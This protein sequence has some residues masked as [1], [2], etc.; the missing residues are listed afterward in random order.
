MVPDG[1]GT[2]LKPSWEP[3]CLARKPLSEKTVA[4]NCLRWG[5]GAINVDGCRVGTADDLNGGRYS[6]N[7]IGNDGATYG[8]G[9]NKRSASDY[10]QPLGR[11]PAN[12]CLSWPEDEYELRPDITK[13]QMRE[14]S[15]WFDEN[16]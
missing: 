1:L 9:I 5:T 6:D 15:R 13:S 11:F 8:A 10:A 3:I 12:L 2:A 7:K 4:A 14:L 16:A